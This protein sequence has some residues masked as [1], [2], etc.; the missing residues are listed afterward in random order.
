MTPLLI[1]S[2]IP[3]AVAVATVTSQVAAS[4]TTGALTYWRRRAVDVKLAAILLIGGIVGTFLGVLF[5]NQMRTVGQLDL[6][7]QLSYVALLG[8]IGL[9]MLVE[10]TRSMLRA[11][12]MGEVRRR[13]GR[14]WFHGLPWKMRFPTS[15]IYISLVPVVVLGVFI[16][17]TGTVLGIGGGFI[18]V[19]ALIYLF[20][21]PTAVVVGTSLFQ[22][23]FTM[24]AATILHALTNQSVDV[25]LALL[26]IVG[27]V[28]GAQFG[29]RAGANIRGEHFR[30][31]LALI[32]LAV[33]VR[34][35][36]ELAVE[37]SEPF[38]IA[39]EVVQ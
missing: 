29:A 4:S 31:L 20:R 5:F 6:I 27:G 19:P 30:F 10:S 16:G 13:R 25:V 2:G 17:F 32:V 33:G 36:I 8:G 22:I 3:P 1:F 28:M 7:I 23:L 24:V 39:G 38:S 21:V 9:A 34:F 12:R 11:R 35:A 18:L 14:A 37:P 15:G 26:L